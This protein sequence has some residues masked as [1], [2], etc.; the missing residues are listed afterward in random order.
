MQLLA[1]NYIICT[2][3]RHLNKTDRKT[4]EIPKTNTIKGK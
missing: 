3:K 2:K 4:N 1:N